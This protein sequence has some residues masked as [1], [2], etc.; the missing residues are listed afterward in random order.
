MFGIPRALPLMN[1]MG[2][3]WCSQGYVKNIMW[4]MFS[5]PTGCVKNIMGMFD[6]PRIMNIMGYVWCFQGFVKKIMGM[7]GLRCSQ[8]YEYHGI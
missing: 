4:G 2:Y 6:V 3:D 8:G 1:I 7:L 5:V